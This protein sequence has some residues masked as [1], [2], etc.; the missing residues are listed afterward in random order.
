MLLLCD[1]GFFCLEW[2][3]EYKARFVDAKQLK[4]EIDEFMKSYDEKKEQVS[5]WFFFEFLR[6]L[7]GS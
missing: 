6:N 3:D 7:K 4:M 1:D 5:F 2:I